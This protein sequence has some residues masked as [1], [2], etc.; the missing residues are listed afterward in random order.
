MYP[1]PS[2]CTFYSIYYSGSQKSMVICIDYYSSGSSVSTATPEVSY[3]L[4][5]NSNP[6]LFAN[7]KEVLSLSLNSINQV[8]TTTGSVIQGTSMNNSAYFHFSLRYDDG[9]GNTSNRNI[10]GIKVRTYRQ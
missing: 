8:Y 3:R 4:Y 10:L 2:S 7:V 9:V 1:A 6:K 5:E